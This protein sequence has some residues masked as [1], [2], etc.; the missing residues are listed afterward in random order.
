MIDSTFFAFLHMFSYLSTFFHIFPHFF[1]VFHICSNNFFHFFSDLF[2]FVYICLHFSHFFTFLHIFSQ[3][4]HNFSAISSHFFT[5]CSQF[6]PT[7]NISNDSSKTTLREGTLSDVSVI[8]LGHRPTPN[9]HTT[10]RMSLLTDTRPT[11]L[12]YSF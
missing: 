5:I 3:L 4:F 9:Q 10:D 12:T 2:T 7:Q 11:R 1:T 6:V 8:Y